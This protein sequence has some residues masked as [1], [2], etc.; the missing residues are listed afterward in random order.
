MGCSHCW[1][2]HCSTSPSCPSFRG[3]LISY[4]FQLIVKQQLSETRAW[5]LSLAPPQILSLPCSRGKDL[6]CSVV[7]VKW[8]QWPVI[9]DWPKLGGGIWYLTSRNQ[10]FLKKI[11]N[12][13]GYN[14]SYKFLQRGQVALYTMCAS[15]CVPQCCG[16]PCRAYKVTWKPCREYFLNK[17]CFDSTVFHLSNF[18]PLI[19]YSWSKNPEEWKFQKT[20]QT[21]LLLHMYDKEKVCIHAAFAQNK[22]YTVLS[23]SYSYS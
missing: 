6:G 3:C 15:V 7:L 13:L 11:S 23:I 19:F 1:G 22:Y 10:C 4:Q 17:E 5:F 18:S 12:L 2:D 8:G 16:I 9:K 14:I 21:W 20:R